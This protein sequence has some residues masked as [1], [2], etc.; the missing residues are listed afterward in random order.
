MEMERKTVITIMEM[1]RE[2][3]GRRARARPKDFDSSFGID[4]NFMNKV[5]SGKSMQLF[6][7]MG[8]TDEFNRD[9][10]EED[11]QKNDVLEP[12]IISDDFE[13]PS[14]MVER[15][16]VESEFQEPESLE[17]MALFSQLPKIRLGSPIPKTDPKVP[18]GRKLRRKF[19][20]VRREALETGGN[21]ITPE[22]D[23][24]FNRGPS[25]RASGN[26]SGGSVF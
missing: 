26:F 16:K 5:G 25:G 6:G 8:F 15:M 7:D 12:S 20:K 10:D 3:M 19:R 9:I 22:E 21:P 23:R 17:E 11:M 4:F 14:E 18:R 2:E 24:D 13:E 1:V